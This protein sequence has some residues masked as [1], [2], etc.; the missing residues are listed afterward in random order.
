MGLK[1]A[2][3]NSNHAWDPI[4]LGAVTVAASSL[5]G[6]Y[7]L[8]NDRSGSQ[9]RPAPATDALLCLTLTLFQVLDIHANLRKRHGKGI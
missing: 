3:L 2:R 4:T 1:W 6:D 8:A 9:Q 5:S 7:V